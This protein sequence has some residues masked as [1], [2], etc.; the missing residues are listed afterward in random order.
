MIFLSSTGRK[1]KVNTSK[2][3]VDWESPSRSKLQTSVKKILREV[4]R[5][6]RVYEEFPVAGTKM[7]I[8]FYNA[9]QEVAIEVDGKQHIQSNKFSPS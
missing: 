3:L 5:G 8:D 4:W 2:Y 9:T 6:D 1:I 7:T